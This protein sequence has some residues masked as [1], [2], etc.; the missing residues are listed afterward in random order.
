MKTK[1]EIYQDLSFV[2]EGVK[3]KTLKS[4]DAR[5][6]TNAADKIIRNA[7]G[8]ILYQKENRIKEPIK[9]WEGQPTPKQMIDNGARLVKEGAKHSVQAKEEKEG[10]G[11]LHPFTK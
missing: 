9:Y 8:E 1:N 2:I 5:E 4:S 7:L 3:N 6:I 10:N 11:S